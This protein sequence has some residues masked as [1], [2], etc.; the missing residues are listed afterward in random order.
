M[1]TKS[2]S[3]RGY[4]VAVTA[5][6]VTGVS[7]LGMTTAQASPP[8][9]PPGC[10]A[11]DVSVSTNE[12]T[13]PNDDERTYELLVHANPG[14]SCKV[15]GGPGN[16]TF[17]GPSGALPIDVAMPVPGSGGKAEVTGDTPAIARMHGPKTEGPARATS[18]SMTLPGDDVPIRTSWV[19]GGVDGPLQADNFKPPLT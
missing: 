9:T 8:P 4:A 14:V 1:R 7:M 5:A 12:V 10:N 6:A 15:E 19:S 3:R 17:Y 16:L 11:D 18:V 2:T 13:A